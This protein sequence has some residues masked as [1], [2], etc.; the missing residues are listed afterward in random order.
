MSDFDERLLNDVACLDPTYVD[1]CPLI[2]SLGTNVNLLFVR[3]VPK[4]GENGLIV[5]ERVPALSV[6]LPWTA[7]LCRS[8]DKLFSA[9]QM[10]SPQIEKLTLRMQ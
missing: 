4:V 10:N 1:D 6:V 9:A 3:L 2:L 5:F 7:N 8:A